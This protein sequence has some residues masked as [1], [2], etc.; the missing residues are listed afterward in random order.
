MLWRIIEA[1]GGGYYIRHD[2][3][4]TTKEA[5]EREAAKYPNARAVPLIREGN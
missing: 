3:L 5:A 1:M 2:G 4:Y